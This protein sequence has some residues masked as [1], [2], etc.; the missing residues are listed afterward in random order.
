M[1]MMTM[2]MTIIIITHADVSS[3]DR[4]CIFV[5]P[6]DVSKPIIKHDEK[7]STMSHGNPFILCQRSKVK[8]TSH[9]TKHCR[10]GFVHSCECWLLLV[11]IIIIIVIMTN[12]ISMSTDFDTAPAGAFLV[13]RS[14]F[15]VDM[16]D[17]TSRRREA[18]SSRVDRYRMTPDPST[19]S[20]QVNTVLYQ[21]HPP[22]PAITE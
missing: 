9:K 5:Y 15:Q 19:S 3:G 22:P 17:T 16:E 4:V 10:R 14:S 18:G 2:M 1:K 7:C 12:S 6:H 11:I 8:V 20:C 21:R 13:S